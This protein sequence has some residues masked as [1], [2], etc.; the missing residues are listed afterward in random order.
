MLRGLSLSET[1]TLF[2]QVTNDN[3]LPH[4]PTIL[5]KNHASYTGT[6]HPTQDRCILYRNHACNSVWI[7][8]GSFLHP[9]WSRNRGA[10]FKGLGVGF[11]AVVKRD[12][13]HRPRRA[14]GY[15]CAAKVWVRWGN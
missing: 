4:L 11:F 9:N 8:F 1:Y 7:S 13:K 12:N 15:V 5:Q 10:A 3:P 6:M 2:R 14:S